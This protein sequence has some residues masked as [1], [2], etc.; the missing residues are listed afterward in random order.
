MPT[1]LKL[2]TGKTVGIYRNEI[3]SNTL[4]LYG[5]VGNI[6]DEED[7]ITAAKVKTEIN[8]IGEKEVTVHIHSYGGDAFE[9]VAVYNI[10]KQSNKNITV[11]VDGIA[12]SA[13]SI[14]AMAGD[15]IQMPKNTQFMIHK[16]ATGLFGNSKKFEKVQKQLE[17]T[18]QSLIETYMECF[19]GSKKELIQFMD[20]EKFF[21]AEEAL[22]WGLIDEIL[23]Y[24]SKPLKQK[25]NAKNGTNSFIDEKTVALCNRVIGER[26]R[27]YAAFVAALDKAHGRIRNGGKQ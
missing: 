16:A 2:M 10:L 11:C 21:S 1:N 9:G 4:Y 26:N 13:A 25:E 8:K 5:P 12:A 23:N 19:T 27:K 22:K 14:I 18:N 17:S 15:K 24:D 3:N 6:F 7:C 20:D